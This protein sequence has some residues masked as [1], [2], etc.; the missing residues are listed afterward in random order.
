[1]TIINRLKNGIGEETDFYIPR[2]TSVLFKT[3]TIRFTDEEIPEDLRDRSLKLL[4]N[5]D[6]YT[7]KRDAQT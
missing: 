7:I 4:F 6:F 5:P 2:N 1:M 3:K